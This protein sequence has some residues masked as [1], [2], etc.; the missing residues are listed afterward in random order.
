MEDLE[1]ERELQ[2]ALSVSPSPDYVARVRAKIA[3]APP[4]SPFVGWLKPAAAIACAVVL[5][6]AA[7]L[8][9]EDT[10][11][12]IAPTK[13]GLKPSTTNLSSTTN[14]PSVATVTPSPTPVAPTLRSARLAAPAQSRASAV[15]PLPEVIIAPGDVEALR[16]FVTSASEVR[17]TASFDQTP[18]PIPWGI[19]ETVDHNN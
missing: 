16:Q 5:T 9:R 13:A 11:P 19:T 15:E 18:A 3:Q 2:A 4:P 17:F 7:T 10:R 12:Q 1:L 14:T 6:I 8:L